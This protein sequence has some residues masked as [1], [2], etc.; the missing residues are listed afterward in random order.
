MIN[1]NDDANPNYLPMIVGRY[2]FVPNATSTS[3]NGA[4]GEGTLRLAPSY[5]PNAVALTRIGAEITTTG[6]AGSKVRLGIYTDDGR[7][8][9]GRL[10][11]DAGQILGDSATVQE[12]TIAVAIG[13]GWYWF[14]GVCQ[15]CPTTQPTV[16]T[17]NSIATIATRGAT[18]PSAA[19]V[20]GDFMTGVTGALPTTFVSGPGGTAGTPRIFIRT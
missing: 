9:P 6:E 8:Q 3:T 1:D 20:L 11:I 14:G 15:S 18:T 4:L 7:G 5:V 12:L 13:P 16:R 19:A 2:Y 10:V 17:P